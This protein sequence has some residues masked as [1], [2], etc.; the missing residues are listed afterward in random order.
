M[1]LIPEIETGVPVPLKSSK[2]A[3]EMTSSEELHA[4]VNTIK[5]LSD[6]MG[7]PIV[8]NEGQQT[9]AEGLARQMLTDPQTRPDYAKYPNETM[10]YLAGMVTQSNCM[11][12]D[13]LSELKLYVV[14]KLVFEVENAATAKDRIAA[15]KS[16]GEIDG[17]DAFKKRTET[18]IKIQPIEE[19][20]KELLTILE[21]VEYAEIQEIGEEI[22]Q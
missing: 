21:G 10:A 13:E 17:V 18:T 12:V 19:V 11:I 20:E 16:L 9:V 7:T 14:N 15:L 8:P 5:Y 2:H 6:L 4:R 3:P 22:P 1:E